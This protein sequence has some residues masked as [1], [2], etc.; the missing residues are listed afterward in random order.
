MA[1]LGKHTITGLI[2]ASARQ[3]KDWTA[4]YRFYSH[5]RFD[6]ESFFRAVRR[7]VVSELDPEKPI[8][9]AMDDTIIRKTSRKTPGVSYRRD[10]LGP[11]FQ[12]NLVLAQRVLQISAALPKGRGTVP[13]RMIPID[14]VHAPTPKKP[15]K[16]ATLEQLAEYKKLKKQSNISLIGA[17]RINNLRR[18]LDQDER[19]R[20][21]KLWI[22]VD[23]SLT[24]GKVIK[25]LPEN[26]ELIGRIREDACLF[27]PATSQEQP[28]SAGRK[29]KYG[30][31]APTPEQLRQDESVPWKRVKAFAV[32]KVHEFKV[33]SIN[34]VLWKA[35]GASLELRLVVIAPLAY[36]LRKGRRLLYRKPAYL[37]CTDPDVPLEQLI[38]AYVWRWDIE[39]NFRDEKQLIG[40]G[41]AQVHN[42]VSVESSP[43]LAVAAYAL[44]LLSGRR[45][46]PGGEI[47]DGLLAPKWMQNKEKARLTTKDLLKQLRSELLREAIGDIGGNLK[48]L[49]KGDSDDIKRVKL[50]PDMISA[51]LYPA[52]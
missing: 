17:L 1:C 42:D 15:G 40:A 9:A 45:A 32:G 39:V 38:Q 52:A 50:E 19:A 10:P 35:S 29:R 46:Y 37:I 27:Y 44:L 8:V 43:A 36:R 4:D 25:R 21:T 3:F 34:R 33:K 18:D 41:E 16:R 20:N 47:E 48:G 24:N 6:K 51:T 30:N 22:V 26:T 5:E 14:F 11:R 31:R 2:C 12:T 13:A 28:C 49:V 23:G 7:E